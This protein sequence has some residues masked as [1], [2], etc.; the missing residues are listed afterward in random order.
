[1]P[2]RAEFSGEL[3]EGYVLGDVVVEPTRVWLVGARSKVLRLTEIATE[4]I[5]LSEITEPVE[6]EVRLLM[7][8]GSVWAEKNEPV[9]VKIDVKSTIETETAEAVGQGAG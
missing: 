7:G 9:V 3:R 8:S 2:V 6:R 1:M 5:D 4:T